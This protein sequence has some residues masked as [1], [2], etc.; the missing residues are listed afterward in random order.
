MNFLV[1]GE[2]AAFTHGDGGGGPFADAVERK[3]G[4]AFERRRVEGRR[5][6]AQMMLAKQ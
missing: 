6:V 4:G 1:N 5:G 3:H 2:V